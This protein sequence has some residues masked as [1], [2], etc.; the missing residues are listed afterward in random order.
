MEDPGYSALCPRTPENQGRRVE[1]ALALQ[2]VG[3]P[4]GAALLAGGARGFFRSLEREDGQPTHN[5]PQHIAQLLVADAA[6]EDSRE[7]IE[8]SHELLKVWAPRDMPQAGVD[9]PT[10]AIGPGGQVAVAVQGLK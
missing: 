10:V 3:T 5:L 2:C 1:L 8:M 9:A 4:A 6:L 7:A